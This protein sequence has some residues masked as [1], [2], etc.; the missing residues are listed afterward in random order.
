MNFIHPVSVGSTYCHQL[1]VLSHLQAT[2]F[3]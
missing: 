2:S 3:L 1:P